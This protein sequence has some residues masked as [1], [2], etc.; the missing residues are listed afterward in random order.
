MSADTAPGG[1][2]AGKSVPARAG[3]A[4]GASRPM[5]CLVHGPSV[6]RLQAGKTPRRAAHAV[7]AM[8]PSITLHLDTTVTAGQRQRRFPA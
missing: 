1:G 2:Q 7:V 4:A 6:V 3:A 8:A 5:A